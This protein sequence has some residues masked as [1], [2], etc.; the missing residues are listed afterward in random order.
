MTN[1][2][3]EDTRRPSVGILA[4]QF[5]L[6]SQT[7]LMDCLDLQ[8]GQDSDKDLE[9]ILIERGLVSREAIEKLMVSYRS[10]VRAPAVGASGEGPTVRQTRRGG[11]VIIKPGDPA[12]PVSPAAQRSTTAVRRDGTGMRHRT[13]T[14]ARAE[15]PPESQRPRW[16]V[17]SLMALAPLGLI[18]VY[19]L[20]ASFTG[21][22]HVPPPAPNSGGSAPVTSTSTP[23]PT[24]EYAAAAQGERIHAAVRHLKGDQDVV[25]RY[26]EMVDRVKAC[27]EPEQYNA[28]IDD[29]GRIVTDA[30][31]SAYESDIRGGYKLVIDAMR[32]RGEQIFGFIQDESRRL[33]DSGRFGE[34][35][36]SWDWF[37]GNIDPTGLLM[38]EIERLRGETLETGRR[39]YRTKRE[40]SEKLAFERKFEQAK[41][42]M[43][44]ALEMGLTEYTDEAYGLVSKFTESEDAAAKA[45]EAAQLEE[46]TLKARAERETT[47]RAGA[48]RAQFWD[49]VVQR[50]IDGADAFLKKQRDGAPADVCKEIDLLTKAVEDIRMAFGAVEKALARLEGR[51]ATVAF[52]DGVKSLSLK[53]VSRGTIVYTREG[54]Q[55]SVSVYTVASA[56]VERAAEGVTDADRREVVRGVALLLRD[57]V[58]GAHECFQRGRTDGATLLSFVERSSAFL[59]KNAPAYRERAEKALEAKD[60]DRA[61]AEFSRLAAIP[62]ERAAALRGRARALFNAGNFVATVLDIEQLFEM[63]DYSEDSIRLLNDSF[64]R[65]TLIAKAIQIY[66]NAR[67]RVP[68]NGTILENLVILY[69][70]I[71]E[72]EQAQKVLVEAKRISGGNRLGAAIHLLQVAS[73]NSFAGQSFKSKFGRYDLET[74]VSQKYA[75]EMAQ[76]MD[77]VYRDYVKVFPYKKNEA[78][79]FHVKIFSSESEFFG[80]Y[81]RVTGSEPSGPYG[82]VLAYYMPL[83]KELVGWNAPDIHE[84]MTHEGLHQYI[85]YFIDQCPIWLNEGY[86]SYFEKSTADEPRF[87]KERHMTAKFL[88]ISK[89][90]PRIKDLILMDGNTFRRHGAWHYGSSWSLIYYLIK[91]GQKSLLDR[92]FEELMQGKSEQQAFDGVFG[93]IDLTKL[94]ARWRK[95]IFDED[96]DR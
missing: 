62:T 63:G 55:F 13:G 16:L 58:S 38:K 43:L 72:Y 67:K 34:A 35:L 96:Y 32:R 84:T 86:A 57:D 69:L 88:L 71:H 19:L 15:M 30:K 87:N 29:L 94:E 70:Q 11:T 48:V 37:P 80:Y 44:E 85:D 26:N 78:L 77:K 73:Q 27:R 45:V 53:S 93:K 91:T 46:F 75:N 92:Y 23:P 50:K 49:L 39:N 8:R 22:G 17:G 2:G 61:I 7:Q 65:S 52:V 66:E 56:E 33:A 18:G 76:F 59:A 9:Q 14:R 47:Q 12:A 74:N 4:V 10:S 21:G 5:G 24:P 54:R 90:L 40:Q 31:G 89:Q 42:L 79:R 81:R 36:R 60:W 6:I 41:L 68:E 25:R 3:A 64:Q 95:A 1:P 28:L 83:T 82:K 20:Y 51:D